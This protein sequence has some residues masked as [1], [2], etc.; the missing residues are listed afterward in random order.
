[1]I[2]TISKNFFMSLAN[3]KSLNK[4]AK[5][6]GLNF[7]ATK[8]V[9]G[10]TIDSAIGAVRHLNNKGIVATLDHLG[11]FVFTEKEALEATDYCIKT[12]EA[13]GLSG[14]KTGLSI[15]I[16]QLGLDI[17]RNFCINNI[18]RILETA[19]R[20]DL[21]VRIDMEDYSHCQDT[22]DITKMFHES[23]QN[24]G[25]VI[26]S[27]LFR[28]LDDVKDLKGIPLRI[29]KGA[30]KESPEVAYQEKKD[31]DENYLNLVKEHLLGGTYTAIASHDH[32]LI[33]KVK[34]FVQ[35][36]NIPKNL[37]EFQMLYG[38]RRTLWESLVSEGYKMRIYVPF[39]NDWFG[40]YMRRLA[41][42]PQNVS[43]AFKGFFSK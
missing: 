23:Y 7:G 19:K 38:F 3:N 41:E 18:K 8:V 4:A 1:M 40:Y 17:D 9:A 15:K 24:V 26:Q 35:E 20:H 28:S 13:I 14:V 21:F 16:T 6:W 43:F 2:E 30:Y 31:I 12:L 22:I 37:F 10:S 11:E 5:K 36:N 25:T 29:V 42:R 34:Q 32:I 39:G 33:E 27:Y